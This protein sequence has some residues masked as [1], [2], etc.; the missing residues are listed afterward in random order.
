[1][2]LLS[3]E[4]GFFR[5]ADGYETTVANSIAANHLREGGLL[6]VGALSELLVDAKR[7]T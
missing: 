6:L 1:V 4:K 7:A 3:P 5:G 2:V